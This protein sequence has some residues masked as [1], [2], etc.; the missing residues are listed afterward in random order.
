[1]QGKRKILGKINGLRN[2]G[3]SELGA[4]RIS[5]VKLNYDGSEDTKITHFGRWL[6]FDGSF[7]NGIDETIDY[8]L[9]ARK[10]GWNIFAIE[11]PHEFKGEIELILTKSEDGTTTRIDDDI[12]KAFERFRTIKVNSDPVE[13][14]NFIYN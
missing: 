6:N 1:M 4:Y 3:G 10:D 5:M 7:D 14:T 2:Y 12:I 9:N 11:N 13:V 8:L